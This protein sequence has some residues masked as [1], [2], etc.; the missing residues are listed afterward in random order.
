MH[1]NIFMNIFSVVDKMKCQTHA[2]L[3]QIL[4]VLHTT[5]CYSVTFQIC[6]RT[7]ERQYN[8]CYAICQPGTASGNLSCTIWNTCGVADY[9]NRLHLSGIPNRLK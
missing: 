2:K 1:D 3:I 7:F 5:F 6:L 4:L 9:A 8:A